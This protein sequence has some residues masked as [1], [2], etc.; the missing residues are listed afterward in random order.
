MDDHGVGSTGDMNMRISAA[1]I[2]RLCFQH[3]VSAQPMLALERTAT[4]RGEQIEVRAKPFGGGIQILDLEAMRAAVGDFRFDSHRSRAE[5]DL[6]IFIPPE[7]KDGFVEFCLEQFR[8]S[9]PA[10]LDTLPERELVE[11]LHDSLGIQVSMAQFKVQWVKAVVEGTP[12]PS[13]S[14]RARDVLTHHIYTIYQV[15]VVDP[16]LAQALFA[17]SELLADEDL[18]RIARQDL[19]RGGWGRANAIL[20]LPWDLLQRAFA[21]CSPEDRHRDLSLFGHCLTSSVRH[22]L[23]AP[24]TNDRNFTARGEDT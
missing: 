21:D 15:S 2:I 5:L 6:R 14:P 16:R 7:K 23:D 9:Q 1:V 22:L 8:S 12:I 11:E 24:A 18:E 4:R 17:N 20:A 13:S 19:A 10:I 3:P